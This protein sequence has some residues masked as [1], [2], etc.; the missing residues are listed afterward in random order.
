MSAPSDIALALL[1]VY[2]AVLSPIKNVLLGTSGCCRFT[3]TCS[4]Y[5]AEALARH[6]LMRGAFLSGKRVLRCHPWGDA[7]Y[8]PVPPAPA[9]EPRLENLPRSESLP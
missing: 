8:D 2:G 6:G 4:C 7:G 3:P 9:L 5:A 1:R